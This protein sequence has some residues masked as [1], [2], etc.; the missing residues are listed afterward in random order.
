MDDDIQQLLNLRLKMMGLGFA[1]RGC[2]INKSKCQRQAGV[3][4]ENLTSRRGHGVAEQTGVANFPK[5]NKF[6]RAV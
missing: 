6:M 3:A 1:H 4:A 2:L 5:G